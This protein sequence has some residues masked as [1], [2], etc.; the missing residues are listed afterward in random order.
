MQTGREADATHQFQHVL[1]AEPERIES[2]LALALC[3]RTRGLINEALLHAE[4]AVTHAPGEPLGWLLKGSL[5][6]LAGDAHRAEVSLRR[7]VALA[8]AAAEAWHY[9]GE[10]LQAQQ[11]WQEAAG[12]YRHAMAAQPGEIVN[13]AACAEQAG[14]LEA[15]RHGFRQAVA[16]MPARADIRTRLAHVAAQLCDFDGESEAVQALEAR[17]MAP[18]LAADDVSEVFALSFLPVSDTAR[19]AA[20]TRYASRVTERARRFAPLPSHP[21]HTSGPIRLGYLSADFGPHAIGTLVRDLFAAHD[22]THFRVHG[23][24]LHRHQ[25][26][27]ANRIRA[28]CD[29]FIDCEYL[30]SEAI[31][32]RIRDDRIDVLIDLAGYTLGSRP[33]VLALKPAPVQLGW[34]GF[35]HPHQAPWLDGLLLDDHV[36][37]PDASWPFD[38]RVIRLPGTLL[39]ASPMPT[40]TRDR[41]RFDLPDGPVLASFNS[42]YKL[43]APLLA[44]WAAIMRRAPDAHLMVYLPPAARAGFMRH[45][46]GLDGDVSRLM[47][48]EALPP[49]E[50]ADRAASCDLMLD[51]FRYQGGATGVAAIGS[52]LPVLSRIGDTLTGRL[53][54]SLNRALGLDELVCADTGTYIDTA[55]RLASDP[56]ALAALRRRVTQAAH[57]A[58]L[59]DPRRSAQAIEMAA[60]AALAQK[61]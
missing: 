14:E 6:Q 1:Q 24:S 22:R 53:G 44:A 32:R 11:R 19:K 51:A 38:D 2:R 12:A 41:R 33:E 3:L 8:P 57:D 45:W 61:R 30:G 40:G 26:V 36:L 9:L 50:Q 58:R 42:A 7:C 17:L 39:P 25:G 59:F 20:A 27:I 47:V 55:V 49:H 35:I 18:T 56:D 16:L 34:L 28:G 48:V 54:V 15:A 29:V 43:D 23:Y 46:V 21:A 4:W 13:I 31:A 52:G 5:Q 60:T 37:S 10:S